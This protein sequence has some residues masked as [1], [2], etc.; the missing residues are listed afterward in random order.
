MLGIAGRCATVV[1]D[2]FVDAVAEIESRKGAFPVGAEGRANGWWQM[3]EAAWL[4]TTA[5]RQRK[6]QRV[7][8]YAH[9]HNP[10]VARL[11]ARDYLTM[12]ERQLAERLNRVVSAELVY[13]AYNVG[14][15]RFRSRGFRIENTPVSTQ[16]ACLRLPGLIEA[17]ENARAPAVAVAA[18]R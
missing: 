12:L 17:A 11:Y 5:Y 1:T 14:F 8:S 16:R 15:S 10:G 7:W 6:G 2:A 18:L 4:D 9:A 13:A 3:H